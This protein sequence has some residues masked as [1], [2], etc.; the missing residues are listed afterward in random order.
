MLVVES[1]RTARITFSSKLLND[2][3]LK[4][5]NMVAPWAR[6][7]I[8][9]SGFPLG[10]ESCVASDREDGDRCSKNFPP[11]AGG[12]WTPPDSTPPSVCHCTPA[13]FLAWFR[14]SQD[15][16]LPYAVTVDEAIPSAFWKCVASDDVLQDAA[17]YADAKS[18]SKIDS[19]S[20]EKAE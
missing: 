18:S 4:Y 17:E 3:A 14:T 8:K 12:F 9:L 11:L 2:M 10:T 16:T 20:Y 13:L 7:G 6:E 19:P 1:P 15:C 5:P